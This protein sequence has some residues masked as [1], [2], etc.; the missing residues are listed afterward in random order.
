MPAICIIMVTDRSGTVPLSLFPSY[1]LIII[2]H[3]TSRGAWQGSRTLAKV[4]EV[5]MNTIRKVDTAAAGDEFVII[6]PDRQAVG[7]SAAKARMPSTAR[8]LPRRL[9][10][11]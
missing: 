7:Y 3:D 9:I 10:S 6:H 4:G 5:I 2:L 8:S 1:F 11:A